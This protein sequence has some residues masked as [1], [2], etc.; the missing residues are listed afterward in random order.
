[1]IELIAAESAAS[2]GPEVSAPETPGVKTAA[3][4]VLTAAAAVL[5]DDELAALLRSLQE[6]VLLRSGDR[7]DETTAC[8]RSLMI[9]RDK[10]G[11]LPTVDDYKRVRESVGGGVLPISR[12][13]KQ[14]GSWRMA[15]EA[16]ELSETTTP[17]RIRARFDSRR[18][19][20]IWRYSDE[21]LRDTIARCVADLGHVPQV[22]EFDWW[23]QRELE[24]ARAQG[25][26]GLH[27][28]STGPY[29]RRWGNWSGALRAFGY[30]QDAIDGRF[31]Q[32]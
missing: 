6:L 10:C 15:R 30:S 9:A 3:V 21:T 19:D 5:T 24:L 18:L 12:I 8:I 28:P 1:M 31:V 11:G 27:L 16:L 32:P 26:G 2:S 13:I 4:D 29:R 23:R 7:G 20:K 25:H 14:F 17:R 22:A